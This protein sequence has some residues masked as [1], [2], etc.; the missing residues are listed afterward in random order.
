MHVHVSKTEQKEERDGA[1]QRRTHRLE[2][3]TWPRTGEE[4]NRFD[5][6]H[7]CNGY[8][9]SAGM[10]KD[11]RVKVLVLKDGHNQMEQRWCDDTFQFMRFSG[12]KKKKKKKRAF[13][14]SKSILLQYISESVSAFFNSTTCSIWTKSKSNDSTV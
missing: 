1:R 12:Y 11:M 8:F 2:L 4:N 6:T 7:V 10:E 13:A 3:E 5:S 14:H 9:C